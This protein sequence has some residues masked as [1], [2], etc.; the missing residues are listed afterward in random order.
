MNYLS[1]FL[2]AFILSYILSPLSI[3]FSKKM[4]ILSKPKKG[5]SI[6]KPCLGGIAIFIAFS[7]AILL[8]GLFVTGFSQTTT[9][10]LIS[11]G[12]IV[13]LG[14]VDDVRE[15]SPRV[16]I[17]VELIVISVLISFGISTKIAFLPVWI[18]YLITA[19][20]ILYVTN[21]FNLLDIMDGLTSG[22]VIIISMTLL[23]ICVV[24]RDI[25]SGVILL[26]LLGSHLGFLRYNYPPAK[27][28]MGDTGS[29]FSG[30]VL[31]VV[32]INISYAPLE[33][34]IALM[35]PVMA[36]S[37]P[38]YD[39]FFLILMR[40]KANKSIFSKTNDH[41][42]FRLQTMNNCAHKS[43]WLMYSISLFIALA[44]LAVVFMSNKVGLI[45]IIAVLIVFI[46]AGRKVAMVKVED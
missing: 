18:N 8:E 36:M 29:L 2:L 25:S 28:Y 27:L 23:M 13:F 24:N 9:G 5:E 41:F 30:F 22:I 39:A 40:I 34:P 38:I 46:F 33:R 4:S 31:A 12:I 11:F 6:G 21:A 17:V 15:L 44:S 37:L 19:L 26:A 45:S 42:V 35:A 10:L 20:W 7:A 1:V 3:K 43:I 16:K 14:I 32:A